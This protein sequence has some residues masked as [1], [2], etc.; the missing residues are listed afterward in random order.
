MSTKGADMSEQPAED[1]DVVIDENPVQRTP[2]VLVLDTS[3]SMAGDDRIEQLNQALELFEKTIKGNETLRQQLM[4]SVIGFG[5]QVD[6]LCDWTQGD[7][8]SAPHLVAAGQ[9]SMGAAMRAAHAAVEEIRT[10]L[11]A[12]GVPYTR[13]WIFLMSDG[14]PTDDWQASADESRKRCEAKRAVVWPFGVSGAN[15]KALHAFARPDMNVYM[16]DE[17]TDFGAIF[18]WLGSSLGA[19]AS[20]TG[21]GALQL[22]PPPALT[23]SVT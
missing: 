14:G 8:F 22:P 9:T 5:S 19:L 17:T 18:E 1:I 16:L 13:P 4:L 7:Q 6:I 21:T 20:S 11:K 12:S 10:K 2:C 3:G 15:T 23:V